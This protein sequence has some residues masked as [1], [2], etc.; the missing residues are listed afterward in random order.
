MLSNAKLAR[1]AKA[2]LEPFPDVVSGYL[3]DARID[4]GCVV[5]RIYKDIVGRYANG[6][7]IRSDEIFELQLYGRQRW[8]VKT[9]GYGCYVIVDFHPHGGRQSLMQL[10]EMYESAAILHSRWPLH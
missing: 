6:A 5:G 8:L 4:R 1:L 3:T 10:A 2:M 9:L 7:L